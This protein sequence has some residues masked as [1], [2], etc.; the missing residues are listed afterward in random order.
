M[1]KIETQRE[2]PTSAKLARQPAHPSMAGERPSSPVP[3][4]V[5]FAGIR[6]RLAS[7]K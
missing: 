2:R 1:S 5:L 3:V 7:E 6:D 4:G